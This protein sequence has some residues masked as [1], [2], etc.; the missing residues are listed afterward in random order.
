MSYS[1]YQQ[2]SYP[3][4]HTY[5]FLQLPPDL[6]DHVKNNK[7]GQ[8]L[9]KS[10]PLDHDRTDG[11]SNSHLVV[12]TNDKTWKLRQMNHSNTV[13]LMNNMNV[14]KLGTEVSKPGPN[15]LLGFAL[16]SYEYELSKSTGQLDISGLPR[17]P[18]PQAQ[19]MSYHELLQNTP[20]SKREF[21]QKWFDLGGCEID[22]QVYILTE[23]YITEVLHHIITTLISQQFDYKSQEGNLDELYAM[24]QSQ[25]HNPTAIQTIIHKFALVT[26]ETFKLD[27]SKISRWFGKQTLEASRIISV[28]DF[29]VNW[30]SSL[31]EF[32]NVPL[33]LSDL[34]GYYFRSGNSIG[35]VDPMKLSTSLPFRFEQLFYLDKSWAYDEIVPLI[36]N[37]V[38]VGKKIDSVIIKYAKKK[39]VGKNSFVVTPRS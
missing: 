1:V 33:D 7:D 3:E 16:G 9:I 14:N 34:K 5:K 38:P 20:I 19:G 6:L 4:N 22:N 31:P 32:Y 25:E 12:C 35:Y 39:R 30:K 8:L 21:E 23:S 11:N 28:P 2:I 10:S 24:A 17:Y 13:M 18:G 27:N 15:Q 37:F 26:N 36:E 29:L